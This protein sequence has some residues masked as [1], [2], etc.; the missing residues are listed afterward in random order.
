MTVIAVSVSLCCREVYGTH[1]AGMLSGSSVRN[2][3]RFTLICLFGHSV[4]ITKLSV[5]IMKPEEKHHKHRAKC[6]K[7]T[8]RFCHYGQLAIANQL[9]VRNQRIGTC[10]QMVC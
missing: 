6:Q 9:T 5:N 8:Y 3:R 4:I 1:Q 2:T 10:Q 7:I